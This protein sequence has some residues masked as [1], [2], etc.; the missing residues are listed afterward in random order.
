MTSRKGDDIPAFNLNKIEEFAE[1][2][3][4]DGPSSSPACY[5]LDS[6][7]KGTGGAASL[8]RLTR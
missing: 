8:P 1:A 3:P 4:A 2:G 6:E 5:Y 7:G